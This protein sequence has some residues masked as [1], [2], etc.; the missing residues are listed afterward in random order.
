MQGFKEHEESKKYDIIKGK[1]NQGTV[2]DH[3][4]M[5]IY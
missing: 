3:K 4:E 5:V 1:K 2:A